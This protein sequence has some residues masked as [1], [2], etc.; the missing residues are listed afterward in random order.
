M[1]ARMAMYSKDVDGSEERCSRQTI[2]R[3]LTHADLWR[4]CPVNQ[5][6]TSEMLIC[7]R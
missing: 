5:S 2:R 3:A 1:P 6:I 7:Y 4:D